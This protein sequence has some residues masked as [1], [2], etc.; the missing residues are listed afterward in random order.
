MAQK[1]LATILNFFR[2]FTYFLDVEKLSTDI[3][4]KK[5]IA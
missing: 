5:T 1:V 4:S 3:N 2:A